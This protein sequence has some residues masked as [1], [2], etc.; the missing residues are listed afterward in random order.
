[1]TSGIPQKSIAQEK[2]ERKI[3]KG[4]DLRTT[5]IGDRQPFCVVSPGYGDRWRESPSPEQYHEKIVMHPQPAT[6]ARKTFTG[7]ACRKT[8]CQLVS[9]LSSTLRKKK[10]AT[11][12]MI[13]RRGGRKRKS[14]SFC[15]V[16]KSSVRVSCPTLSLQTGRSLL[17]KMGR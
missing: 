7:S 5:E 15:I 10:R 11:K 13:V 6:R 16:Q 9:L 14:L 2:K 3:R 4:N 1:M 8:H 17:S 12:D